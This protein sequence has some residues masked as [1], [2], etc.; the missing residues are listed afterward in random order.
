MVFP[1]RKELCAYCQNVLKENVTVEG[2]PDMRLDARASIR[3]NRMPQEKHHAFHVRSDSS[4]ACLSACMKAAG[5][6]FFWAV[7][8]TDG[9]TAQ[10]ETAA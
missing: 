9:T 1:N 2:W 6:F 5:T 8:R 4:F 7:G 10:F 3:F